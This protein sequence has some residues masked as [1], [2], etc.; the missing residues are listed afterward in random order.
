MKKKCPF[1][2]NVIST[3][4]NQCNINEEGKKSRVPTL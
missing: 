4:K 3:G 2:L 1:E